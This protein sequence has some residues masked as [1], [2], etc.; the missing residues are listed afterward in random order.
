MTGML[1]YRLLGSVLI[2]CLMGNACSKSSGGQDN[3]TPV[4]NNPVNPNLTSDVSSWLTTGN[5]SSL[6]RKETTVLAFGTTT[7]NYPVIRVDSTQKFQS[8]DGFGYTLTQ[9]SAIVINQL[10]A[11]QRNTLLTEI[12]GN[13][14]F[15]FRVT[16]LNKCDELERPLVAEFYQRCFGEDLPE[17]T[18]NVALS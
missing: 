14:G 13:V 7:N 10:P 5:K 9:G 17:S 15:A 6:L 2:F 16:F 11:A 18:A 3:P 12:F 1:T 8:V 4:V